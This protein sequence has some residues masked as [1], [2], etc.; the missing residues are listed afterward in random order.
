MK[1][2]ENQNYMQQSMNPIKFFWLNIYVLI[3]LMC[4]LDSS[5]YF[6]KYSCMEV[7][8]NPNINKVMI[9]WSSWHRLFNPFL[10]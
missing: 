3:N 10:T 4:F 7:L 2:K 8:L 5:P 6:N 9:V 1:E